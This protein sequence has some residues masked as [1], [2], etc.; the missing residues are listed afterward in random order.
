VNGVP[1]WK[2][3]DNEFALDCV[4]ARGTVTY[5]VNDTQLAKLVE[6]LTLT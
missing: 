4:K 1:F 5:F 6:S 2:I 3:N